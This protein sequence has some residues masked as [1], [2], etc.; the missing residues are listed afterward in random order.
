MPPVDNSKIIARY[1]NYPPVPLTGEQ[2][3]GN[4]G[5]FIG[6][7]RERTFWMN[8]SEKAWSKLKG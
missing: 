5:I 6:D 1:G 3:N 8:Y 2:L 4:L 7:Y